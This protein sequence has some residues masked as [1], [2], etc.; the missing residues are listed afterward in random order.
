MTPTESSST[1]V[2][3]VA[4]HFAKPETV[5][6]VRDVLVSLIPLSRGEPGC[7]K[8]ELFQNVSDPTDFTFMEAFASEAALAIHAA[9]PYVADIPARLGGLMAKPSDV[10]VYRP[11]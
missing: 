7:L 11:V 1:A 4:R 6:E 3:V 5:A 2:H 8:Y 10:R 9:A